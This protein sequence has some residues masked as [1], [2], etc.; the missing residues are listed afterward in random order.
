MISA[1]G[2]NFLFAFL[3]TN[4]NS[5]FILSAQ[6][7]CGARNW[8]ALYIWKIG[9]TGILPKRDGEL[10]W[11]LHSPYAELGPK[12]GILEK[13]SQWDFNK[14]ETPSPFAITILSFRVLHNFASSL[15][16]NIY[17]FNFSFPKDNSCLPKHPFQYWLTPNL[18]LH[19]HWADTFLSWY[20]HVYMEL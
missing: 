13:H 19:F 12:A 6:S 9:F 20:F 2:R 18:G 3:E 8:A 4:G 16:F 5:L 17:Y 11:I 7:V 14:E 10:P 1:L 15:S